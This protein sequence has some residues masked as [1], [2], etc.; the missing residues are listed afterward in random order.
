MFTIIWIIVMI[1]SPI[2]AGVIFCAL[3]KAREA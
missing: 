2:A 3:Q 1:L